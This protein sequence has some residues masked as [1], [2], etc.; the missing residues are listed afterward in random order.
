M[1]D[2]TPVARCVAHVGGRV[3]AALPEVQHLP[4][5]V[6]AVRFLRS[7]TGELLFAVHAHPETVARLAED[8]TTDPD[9]PIPFEPCPSAGARDMFDDYPDQG[10]ALLEVP[11]P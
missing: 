11:H 7:G 2:T 1:S 4:G 3:I 8:M 6:V 9:A 5:G 10:D